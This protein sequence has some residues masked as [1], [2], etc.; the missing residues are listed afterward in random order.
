M[1]KKIMIALGIVLAICLVLMICQP[2]LPATPKDFIATFSKYSLINEIALQAPYPI[3]GDISIELKEK[4]FGTRLEAVN[5]IACDMGYIDVEG[6]T[7]ATYK[8]AM[9]S[10]SPK[11]TDS[12]ADKMLADLGLDSPI[13]NWTK[14]SIERDGIYYQVVGL[15]DGGKL[16]AIGTSER[17]VGEHAIDF[18][19][20][21]HTARHSPMAVEAFKTKFNAACSAD[22]DCAFKMENEKLTK[23]NVQDVVQ[24]WIN[25]YTFLNVTAYKSGELREVAVMCVLSDDAAL[26]QENLYLA[27]NV[28][29]KMIAAVGDSNHLN[30]IHN[31]LNLNLSAEQWI[32]DIHAVINSRTYSTVYF[33]GSGGIPKALAMTIGLKME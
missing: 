9:M 23:G 22:K 6:R 30:E 10:A 2:A 32:N 1:N 21:V 15:S 18:F 7:R 3:D 20:D 11:L 33:D 19:G 29:D 13:R 27:R 25:E 12:D 5:V 14:K 8:M 24:A 26:N 16:L 31:R 28:Y 4:F 17:I